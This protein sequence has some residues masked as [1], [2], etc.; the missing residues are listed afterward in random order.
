MTHTYLFKICHAL[1]NAK[2]RTQESTL[3][4][5]EYFSVILLPPRIGEEE[6]QSLH[7]P[8]HNKTLTKLTIDKPTID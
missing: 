5:T 8:P 2:P 3:P 1:R 7:L 6:T 4:S